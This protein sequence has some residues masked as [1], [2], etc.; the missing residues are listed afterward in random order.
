MN[1]HLFNELTL[2][3]VSGSHRH[4]LGCLMKKNNEANTIIISLSLK[5]K[6]R[7]DIFIKWGYHNVTKKF[8]LCGEFIV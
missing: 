7:I 1:V 2:V 8:S 4:L 3:W 5:T 6:W